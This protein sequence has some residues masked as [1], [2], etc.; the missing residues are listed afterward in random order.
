MWTDF[1]I[2]M[3]VGTIFVFVPTYG[4]L[5]VFR[6]SRIS[7]VACAPIL[8]LLFYSVL[9]V[10]YGKMGIWTDGWMLFVP[11]CVVVLLIGGAVLL[12]R[13]KK[14]PLTLSSGSNGSQKRWRSRGQEWGLIL[15]YV[16]I[17]VIVGCYVF[18][19]SLSTPDSTSY[20][21]DDQSHLGYIRSF[22]ERG[23]FSSIDATYEHDL[24]VEGGYYPAAWHLLAASVVTMC[25]VAN[26]VG[27]NVAL[28][29]SCVL[30]FPLGCLF[31]NRVL[32]RNDIAL[33]ITGAFLTSVSASFPWEFIYYGRL[34]ANLLAFCMVPAMVAC[35]IVLFM[36]EQSRGRRIR[37]ILILLASFVLSLF[38]QPSVCFTWL[39][40]SVPFLI[41]VIWNLKTPKG[42][43]KPT[44]LRIMR[45]AL[46]CLAVFVFLI[47]C[48]ML[49]F[50]YGLTRF[51]W[52]APMTMTDAIAN[53]ALQGNPAEC[54]APVLAI[55]VV[56][57]IVIALRRR[58]MRWL[59][60]LFVMFAVMYVVDAGTNL[61]LKNYLTGWWYTDSHRVLAMFAI[62]S[63]PLAVL[64][65]GAPLQ[66][67]LSKVKPG[68]LQIGC[69]MLLSGMVTVLALLPTYGMGHMQFMSGIGYAQGS[70]QGVYNTEQADDAALLSA[71]ER[72]FVQK[73]AEITGD[74]LVFNIPKDG[75]AFAYQSSGMRTYMRWVDEGI[76][77]NPDT[78]LIQRG[79]DDIT[80][81]ASVRRAVDNLGIKYVLMLDQGH[82]PFHAFW[83]DYSDSNW[84]GVL[85][86]NEDTPGFELVL[87]EG[88][89]MRLYR[90]LSEEEVEAQKDAA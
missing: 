29:I 37:C 87:S 28:F 51:K 4:L 11:L 82:E 26:Y 43:A 78:R 19:G 9:A 40:F 5:R 10:L 85:D 81:N 49:P 6:C 67:I 79:L 65:L 52:P 13:A 41:Q 14:G 30:I 2:A 12:L 50:L 45:V 72:R 54:Y 76:S 77:G 23:N 80:T 61:R 56:V 20:N 42:R 53:I 7:S 84:K 39:F 63:Y 58:E 70:T 75:S 64:G 88:D 83:G 46:F 57:G 59:V 22:I 69:Q 44:R 8:S 17:G 60:L 48:Y 89:D 68:A 71:S 1:W 36:P 32:F 62:A 35:T 3:F 18:L 90:I 47:I 86:I 73:A 38:T 74:E 66:K 21:Y 55:L 15:L 33:Q 27:A 25:G 31:L 16:V 24:G 34:S